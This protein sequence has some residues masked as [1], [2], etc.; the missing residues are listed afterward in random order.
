MVKRVLMVLDKILSKGLIHSLIIL[1][2]YQIP[3][4]LK[5]V[6]M[7]DPPENINPLK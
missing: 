5:M 7:R 4:A 2:K 3:Q 1:T 6:N